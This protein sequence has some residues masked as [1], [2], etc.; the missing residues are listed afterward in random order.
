M[1]YQLQVSAGSGT[2]LT[3]ARIPLDAASGMSWAV[4]AVVLLVAG[5]GFEVWRRKFR[6]VWDD[7]EE[8]IA[9]AIKKAEAAIV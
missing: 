8:R 3:V 4:A 2:A 9:E 7:G 6:K 1:A 5:F